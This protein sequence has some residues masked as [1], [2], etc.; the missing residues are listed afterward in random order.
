MKFA[1]SFLLLLTML[2]LL[3]GLCSCSSLFTKDSPQRDKATQAQ[4]GRLVHEVRNDLDEH[5]RLYRAGHHSQAKSPLIQ[6]QRNC[7]R[8][9]VLA[10]SLSPSVPSRAESIA[11]TQSVLDDIRALR[12]E[13][14]FSCLPGGWHSNIRPSQL[15]SIASS[16]FTPDLREFCENFK[17]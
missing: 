1:H 17:K 13:R 15:I 8:A 6:A 2:S 3:G 12:A 11:I 10:Q 5:H 4:M 7:E 14:Y 9:L 16:A